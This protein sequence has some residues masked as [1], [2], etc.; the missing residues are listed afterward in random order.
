M[1]LTPDPVAERLTQLEIKA[2][3]AEDLLEQLNQT[4]YAQQQ[5][6]E[7]LVREVQQLRSQPAPEHGTRLHQLRDELPPHY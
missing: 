3:Y 7:R 2:C 1:P 5:L 6:I 4:V